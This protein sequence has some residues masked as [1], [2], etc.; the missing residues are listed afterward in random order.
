MAPRTKTSLPEQTGTLRHI[1]HPHVL[2]KQAF[3]DIESEGYDNDEF[4]CDG[5][6]AVGSGARYHCKQCSFDLHEAC[7]TC[8]EFH[9]SFIHPNHPLEL[10]WEGAGN[11]HGQLRLCSVCGD[12]VKGL[13]YKCSSGASEDQLDDG[14]SHNF[15]IHPTCSKFQP[16]LN[17][18]IDENHPLRLQSVP[19]IPD[20]WCAICKSLVSSSSW[21]YR[22]DPCD[23]NIHPHCVTLPYNNSQQQGKNYEFLSSATAQQVRPSN[24]SRQAADSSSQ[25]QVIADSSSQRQVADDEAD[26]SN[27]STASKYAAKMTAKASKFIRSSKRQVAKADEDTIAAAKYAAKATGKFIIKQLMQGSNI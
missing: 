25:R 7:G 19:A 3:E 13:F 16:Q 6:S 14:G 27:S 4:A 26:A 9:T 21:S 10:I 2:T 12:K 11:D 17:H 18:A 5:C 8:P 24:S 23:L 15:F 22:C 20:A 1:T